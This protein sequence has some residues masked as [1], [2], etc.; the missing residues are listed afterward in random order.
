[1]IGDEYLFLRSRLCEKTPSHSALPGMYRQRKHMRLTLWGVLQN[2]HPLISAAGPVELIAEYEWLKTWCRDISWTFQ[3]RK[4]P[5]SD[6]IIQATSYSY[7]RSRSPGTSISV[8]DFR[9]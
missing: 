6:W 1:M 8:N 2:L 7:S 5:P 9:E 4:I 3:D